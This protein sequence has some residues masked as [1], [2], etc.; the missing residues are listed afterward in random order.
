MILDLAVLATVAG[1]T[2]LPG[3]WAPATRREHLV[4]VGV[5]TCALGVLVA[6]AV[7]LGGAA[8]GVARLVRQR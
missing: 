1:C 3:A 4:C 6:G 7:A 8:A 2:A 5:L